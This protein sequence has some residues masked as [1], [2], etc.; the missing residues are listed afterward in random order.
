MEHLVEPSDYK[1]ERIGATRDMTPLEIFAAFERAA[2]AAPDKSRAAM[3]SLASAYTHVA[4][5][6]VAQTAASRAEE[7]D[8]ESE[9]EPE[10]EHE[11]E[12]WSVHEDEHDVEGSEAEPMG[13]VFLYPSHAYF[14][15]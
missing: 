12:G 14:A 13:K 8:D 5:W 15:N 6:R 10:L 2:A 9:S 1:F 11:F 4:A 3:A 7:P